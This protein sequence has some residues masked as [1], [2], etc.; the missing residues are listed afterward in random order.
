[1]L[2]LQDLI[3]YRNDKELTPLKRL[4][5]HSIRW[6]SGIG[7]M[8]QLI[9]AYCSQRQLE[10]TLQQSCMRQLGLTLDFNEAD[11]NNIPET[12]P[13]VV[14]ANHPFGFI[15]G[16]VVEYLVSLRRSDLKILSAPF[17]SAD[18]F[19]ERAKYLLPL[20][21]QSILREELTDE[22]VQTLKMA[23]AH[24]KQ[25]GA[26]IVFPAG[27]VSLSSYPLGGDAIDREW[28]PFVA[29]VIA[30]SQATVVPIY[31]A[32][33][34][35]RLFQL[36]SRS[37]ITLMGFFISREQISKI[38]STV[39]LKIGTQI[40]YVTLK[41]FTDQRTLTRYLRFITDELKAS[42]KS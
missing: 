26:L 38:G 31:I 14:V 7:Y 36:V 1:V 39:K 32:G 8:D 37:S 41:Q 15:D 35:S 21:L 3:Y 17:G 40:P 34:N 22:D 30:D 25:G 16:A 42:I 10:E 5:K 27:F 4:A 11:L 9:Q 23:I 28:K 33:Q 6:F 24:V 20:K 29:K 18:R 19:P 2:K 13:T 12:G